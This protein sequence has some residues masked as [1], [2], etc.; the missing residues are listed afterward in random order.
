MENESDSVKGAGRI[1]LKCWQLRKQSR[2]FFSWLLAIN[3]NPAGRGEKSHLISQADGIDWHCIGYN[4]L[5]YLVAGYTFAA[6]LCV[7]EC[8]NATTLMLMTW[9]CSVN[10]PESS[11][12]DSKTNFSHICPPSYTYSLYVSR[13]TKCQWPQMW[14]L[15]ILLH[16]REDFGLAKKV[17][18]LCTKEWWSWS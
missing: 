16:H 8:K 2:P 11:C 18:S 3:G 15:S 14:S 4:W 17:I 5:W 1:L 9:K 10:L 6:I 7:Q 12:D 13:S